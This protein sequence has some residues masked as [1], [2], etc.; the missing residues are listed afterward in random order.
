MVTVALLHCVH[1]WWRVGLGMLYSFT[2]VEQF[3]WGCTAL[4]GLNS[5]ADRYSY[6]KLLQ[7]SMLRA[8][9]RFNAKSFSCMASM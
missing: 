3:Y 5:G 1:A 4:L 7:G 6:S 2:G 9:A 8:I